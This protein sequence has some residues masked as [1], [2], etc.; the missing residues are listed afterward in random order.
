M[1]AILLYFRHYHYMV[2]AEL[3]STKCF[4]LLQCPPEAF[5]PDQVS[6][7]AKITITR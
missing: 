3:K 5:L 6:G 7:N 1:A 2:L 4:P